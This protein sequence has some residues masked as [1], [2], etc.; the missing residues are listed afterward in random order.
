M[1]RR[2]PASQWSAGS[3]AATLR[4]RPSSELDTKALAQLV[5]EFSRVESLVLDG[6]EKLEVEAL[7]SLRRLPSLRALTVKSLAGERV[8]PSL[9]DYIAQLTALTMLA[10]PAC[11]SMTGRLAVVSQLQ[12]LPS[13]LELDLSGCVFLGDIGL[14]R[15]AGACTG[16]TS[17]NLSGMDYNITDEG[18]AALGARDPATG[19]H[20]L[21]H[22]RELSLSGCVKLSG[23]GLGRLPAGLQTLR[24]GFCSNLKDAGVA[25]ICTSLTRLRALDLSYCC[26][27]SD[28]ALASLGGLTQISELS[29]SGLSNRKV[30][31]VAI[32]R[33]LQEK[34]QLAVLNLW[35]C[36]QVGQ[37]T[38]AALYPARA[39]NLRELA[40]SSAGLGFQDIMNL[41]AT[42][43]AGMP[44]LETLEITRMP[45]VERAPSDEQHTMLSWL[46]MPDKQG[47]TR[48]LRRLTVSPGF[49]RGADGSPLH[50]SQLR[51]G[52]EVVVKENPEVDPTWA[53][54]WWVPRR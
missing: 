3:G 22:L 11:L 14:A 47:G 51:P 52:L 39:A 44:K 35:Y 15:L 40:L 20:R 33:A 50:A 9:M 45:F 13:L 31:D 46:Y 18:A 54:A 24:L 16:L 26:K 29:L 1:A 42:I 28:A 38:M 37:S 4:T 41:L 7:S 25:E 34:A 53:N 12:R 19:A 5:T 2:R 10:L 43:L 8:G 30:S 36:R 17:L 49:L 21:G 6:A 23:R 32:G 27:L 48:A